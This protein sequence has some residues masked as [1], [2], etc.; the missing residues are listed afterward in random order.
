MF[1]NFINYIFKVVHG[2][3]THKHTCTGMHIHTHIHRHVHTWSHNHIHSHAG[4]RTK[5]AL[6]YCQGVDHPDVS[7][8]TGILS[9]LQR[10]Y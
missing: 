6:I 9:C 8:G 5:A 10:L 3:S 4:V 7:S 1:K 2:A